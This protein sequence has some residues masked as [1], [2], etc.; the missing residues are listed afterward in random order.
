MSTQAPHPE[1][2]QTRMKAAAQ[3]S[4]MLLRPRCTAGSSPSLADIRT[5]LC[6]NGLCRGV[7]MCC[8]V[9]VQGA[10]QCR[11]GLA[12]P[13]FKLGVRQ[14]LPHNAGPQPPSGACHKDLQD[15]KA[16]SD[17]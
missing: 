5:G 11:V 3:C 13:D 17:G 4:R 6:R 1:V 12:C 15:A 2:F 7:C 10:E 9:L 8:C 16:P 14:K